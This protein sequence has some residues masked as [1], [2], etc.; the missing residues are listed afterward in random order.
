MERAFNHLRAEALRLLER[1]LGR[2]LAQEMIQ[3]HLGSQS[4]NEALRPGGVATVEASPRSIIDQTREVLIRSRVLIDVA[5]TV[6]AHAC[7][8]KERR[9]TQRGQV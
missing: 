2:E 7:D 4:E 9:I 6:H 8:V 3:N 1:L 5:W